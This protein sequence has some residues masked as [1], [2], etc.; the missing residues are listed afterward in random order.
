[1]RHFDFYTHSAVVFAFLGGNTVLKINMII[2]STFSSVFFC[3]C[4]A[5]TYSF[6]RNA[7]FLNRFRSTLT[8]KL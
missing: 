5:M 2:K 7:V 3:V 6:L 1:M 4:I 8:K